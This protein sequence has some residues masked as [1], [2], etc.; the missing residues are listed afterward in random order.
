MESYIFTY[1][2]PRH[3]FRLYSL[4]LLN[5]LR[6]SSVFYNTEVAVQLLVVVVL[7]NWIITNI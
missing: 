4:N 2:E 6:D 7:V 5:D 1:L 3:A